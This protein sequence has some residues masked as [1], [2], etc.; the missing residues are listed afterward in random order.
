MTE[1]RH[2]RLASAADTPSNDDQHAADLYA[3]VAARCGWR[4]ARDK[5]HRH[6]E[7]VLVV[8][9]G[10]R[11]Q[12]KAWPAKYTSPGYWCAVMD[13]CKGDRIRE[14]YAPRDVVFTEMGE[15]EKSARLLTRI[16]QA[17]TWRQARTPLE[18]LSCPQLFFLVDALGLCRVIGRCS[19]A[20]AEEAVAGVVFGW[21]GGVR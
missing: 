16:A 2:G 19:R 6:A 3:F 8:P 4:V 21:R 12:L 13:A 20:D 14:W 10:D 5:Y 11:W 7:R 18:Q 17:S 1:K 9:S 15:V